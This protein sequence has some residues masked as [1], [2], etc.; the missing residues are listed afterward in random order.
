MANAPDFGFD[1]QPVGTIYKPGLR[2]LDENNLNELITILPKDVVRPFFRKKLPTPNDKRY[3]IKY[4]EDKPLPQFLQKMITLLRI[5]DKSDPQIRYNLCLAYC[6][7]QK[8]SYNTVIR[9][10]NLLLKHKIFSTNDDENQ[11]LRKLTPDPLVFKHNVH[12]R[13]V[14]R[15]LYTKFINYL[16]LNFNKFT[17]PLLFAVLTGLRTTEIL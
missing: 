4:F 13:M 3:S 17:A 10:M 15:D 12:N 6:R 2:T 11:K 7:M 1:L 8:Y 16:K 5:D 14:D 9:Y